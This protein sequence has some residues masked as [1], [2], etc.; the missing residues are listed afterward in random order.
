MIGGGLVSMLATENKFNII[1]RIPS[2]S[3]Y[4]RINLEVKL[5]VGD[6]V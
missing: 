3:K 6:L 5:W 1:S 2:E 4:V